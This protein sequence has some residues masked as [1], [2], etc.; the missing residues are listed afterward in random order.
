[1]K[2]FLI[3]L[4]VFA[5]VRGAFGA[6]DTLDLN[7]ASRG[8]WYNG[9]VYDT[10]RGDLWATPCTIHVKNTFSYGYMLNWPYGIPVTFINN[11][12]FNLT[13]EYGY[14][15]GI[16]RVTFPGYQYRTFIFADNVLN[17]ASTN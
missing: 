8:G 3:V 14:T 4:A 16:G 17:A 12:S 15:G 5:L 9:R 6:V 7:D 11:T 13:I 10:N 1:M 2:K